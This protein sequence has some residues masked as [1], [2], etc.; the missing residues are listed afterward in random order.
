MPEDKH[1]ALLLDL[2]Q[3]MGL[4]RGQIELL[5]R[6]RG[7][8]VEARKEMAAKLS[9][10]D[11]RL[12]ALD[13]VAEHVKEMRPIVTDYEKLRQNINGGVI[14]LGGIGAVLF[15]CIGFAVNDLWSFAKS[16][17]IWS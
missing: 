3:D 2:H 8:A 10:V 4:L 11:E 7:E 6:D 16:H 15:T 9:K 17:L 12:A 5:V 14:V 1:V 13:I